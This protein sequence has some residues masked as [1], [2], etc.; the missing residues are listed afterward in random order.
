MLIST[1]IHSFAKIGDNRKIIKMLKEA[2]FTAYDF[3]L[4]DG[5]LADE[6]LLA[7]DYLER[8]KAFRAYADE[9]GIAC[10]QTH[11]PMPTMTTRIERCGGLSLEDFNAK[12]YA[13]VCRAIEVSGILGAKVV[14]IHPYNDYNAEQNA[15]LYK[16]FEET[17]RKAGVKIGVENMWNWDNEKQMATKASCSHH[18]DFKAHLDLLDEE[19]FVACL[20]TGHAEMYGLNTNSVQMIKTLGDRLQALHIHDTDCYHDNHDLPYTKKIPFADILKTLKEYGYK[21]DITMEADSYARRFPLELYPQ[22]MRFMAEIAEYMRKTVE[23][24]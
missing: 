22:A 15:R 20:D 7:D 5:G 24:K 3:S 18:D 21:G 17:A 11:A 23:E 9:I 13:K 19:I 16:S 10:N 14:V 2:G 4:F 1:E 8:A 12:R 6:I